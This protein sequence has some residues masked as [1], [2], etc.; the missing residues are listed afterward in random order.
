MRGG[1]G[2]LKIGFS[3]LHSAD[4]L[5]GGFFWIFVGFVIDCVIE[6]KVRPVSSPAQRLVMC[7][8]PCALGQ[9]PTLPLPHTLPHSGTA[10]RPPASSRLTLPSA[11]QWLTLGD[12]VGQDGIL[13]LINDARLTGWVN[14]VPNDIIFMVRHRAIPSRHPPSGLRVAAFPHLS[15]AASP[16]RHGG[17]RQG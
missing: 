11:A 10:V 15:L 3:N 4:M 1:A 7:R 12:A 5:A 6:W 14:L 16:A 2:S 9:A 13:A 8:A 17:K